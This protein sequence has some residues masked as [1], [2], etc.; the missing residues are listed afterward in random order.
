M[1]AGAGAR[2]VAR[3]HPVLHPVGQVLAVDHLPERLPADLR[4][5]DL[6]P[7]DLAALPVD[8][9]A[10]AAGVGARAWISAPSSNSSQPSSWLN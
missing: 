10:P 6:R 5:A 1:R 9:V 8:A 7:A 2:F 3:E 4:P